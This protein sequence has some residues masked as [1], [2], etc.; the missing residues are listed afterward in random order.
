MGLAAIVFDVDG[1]LADTERDGHLPACNEAFERLGV[2]VRWTWEEWKAL[3][4]IPTSIRRMRLAMEKTGHFDDPLLLEST[5][6]HLSELKRRLYREKY[7]GRLALRPGV[8]PLVREA[9]DRGIRL[10]IVS[11]SR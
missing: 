3:L 9:L 4:P 10:A 7:V 11:T 5:L 1:T 2:P 6:A 8:R